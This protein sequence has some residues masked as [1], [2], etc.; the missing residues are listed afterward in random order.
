MKLYSS[1]D[2]LEYLIA[3]EK[4]AH[5]LSLNVKGVFGCTLASISIPVLCVSYV[6]IPLHHRFA[7]LVSMF[8]FCWIATDLVSCV[9]GLQS[10]RSQSLTFKVKDI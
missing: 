9:T 5:N 8:V 4:S 3:H 10:T 2:M 1:S 6:P 7:P